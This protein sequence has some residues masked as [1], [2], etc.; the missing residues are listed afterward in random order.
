M[1]KGHLAIE[2]LENALLFYPDNPQIYLG[3]AKALNIEGKTGEAE[4]FYLRYR[5]LRTAEQSVQ[6]LSFQSTKPKLLSR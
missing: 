5:T 2:H 3:I 6:Q 1:K 4:Q